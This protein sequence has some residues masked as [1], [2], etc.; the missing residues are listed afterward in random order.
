MKQV[1]L[2]AVVFVLQFIPLRLSLSHTHLSRN[3]HFPTRERVVLQLFQVV[4]RT[5]FCS[6]KAR[7]VST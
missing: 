3:E 4:M 7:L 5:F 6:I 1:H 2:A